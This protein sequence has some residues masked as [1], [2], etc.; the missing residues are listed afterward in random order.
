MQSSK[1]YFDIRKFDIG[2]VKDAKD[3]AQKLQGKT[4]EEYK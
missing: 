4:W 2:D 1:Q 3:L